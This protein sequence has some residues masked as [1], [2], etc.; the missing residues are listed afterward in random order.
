MYTV[1]DQATMAQVDGANNQSAPIV[2]PTLKP[3]VKLMAQTIATGRACFFMVHGSIR[4]SARLV[5][6]K[7]PI[8]TTAEVIELANAH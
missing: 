6:S 8:T 2:Q 1:M 5:G 7:L 4:R 3:T